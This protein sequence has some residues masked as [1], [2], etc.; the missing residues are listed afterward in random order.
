MLLIHGAGASSH[1]WASLIPKLQ[2]FQILTVDLPG[3][4]FTKNKKRNKASTRYYCEGFSG[5][6]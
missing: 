1:S 6:F 4:R 3:H 5:S 2:E